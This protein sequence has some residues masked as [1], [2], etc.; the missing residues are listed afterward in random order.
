M[1]GAA[2]RI[3]PALD[4]EEMTQTFLKTLKKDSVERMII[5][6]PSNFSEMVTMGTRLEEVVREGSK[7]LNPPQM[8]QRN[9]AMAI[10]RRRRQKSGWYLPRPIN[11][12]LPLPLSMLLNYRY[13]T[14]TCN[15][16]NIRSS[17]H[18]TISILYHRASLRSLS[19]LLLSRCNNSYRLNSNHNNSKV[20][21]PDHLSLQYQ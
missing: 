5:A 9:M 7:K 17:H 1:E 18:S 3:T 12:W 15:T 10:I 2:A 11:L 14:N 13:H 4:E 21:R 6:A 20:L 16:P 8:H 19:T